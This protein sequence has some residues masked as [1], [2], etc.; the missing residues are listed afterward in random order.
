MSM[1][2]VVA[3]VLIAGCSS[4]EAPPP[5][6]APVARVEAAPV[7]P[8]PPPK[9]VDLSLGEGYEMRHVIHD[10][11]VAVVPIVATGAVAARRYITL[12]DA[13]KRH[14][15]SVR[16]LGQWEVDTVRVRNRSAQ[17][18]LVVAGELVIDAHQDRVFSETT[19]LAASSTAD[20]HV[21]C[22]EASR[23]HG[24]KEFHSGGALADVELRRTV[25]HRDQTAVWAEVDRTNQRLG[26]APESKTYRLAA[27]LQSDAAITARRDR[28]IAQLDA[29]P[30]RDRMVGLALAID[31]EVLAIDRFA[32]PELYR[33][34][35][36]ELLGSYHATDAGLPHE[37]RGLTADAVR[38]LAKLDTASTTTEASFSALR[39]FDDRTPDPNRDSW[40]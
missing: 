40:E 30:D 13:M 15:V 4:Q 8:P 5:A 29:R 26:L 6:P 7:P 37:H 19:I 3:A 34:L 33:T 32:S 17:P 21:R 24:G 39:P 9:P 38:A 36:R 20:L 16:E 10:G 18:L 12:H 22:V 23:D 35:E 1:R 28:L 25:A 31:G 14:Q 2:V 27:S 11:R